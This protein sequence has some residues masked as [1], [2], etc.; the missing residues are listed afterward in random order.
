MKCFV[1]EENFEESSPTS[2]KNHHPDFQGIFWRQFPCSE[3]GNVCVVGFLLLWRHLS[4]RWKLHVN[5]K[6]VVKI[7]QSPGYPPTWVFRTWKNLFIVCVKPLSC[8]QIRQ[9]QLHLQ[10]TYTTTLIEMFYLIIIMI[11]II[12]TIIIFNHQPFLPLNF[13]AFQ[14]Y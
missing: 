5:R 9:P 12:I 14:V 6:A 7:V 3:N 11:I 1:M 4:F 8:H 13:F 10:S 2:R